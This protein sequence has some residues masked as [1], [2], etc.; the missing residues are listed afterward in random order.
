M[1]FVVCTRD[2]PLALYDQSTIAKL[3]GGGGGGGGGDRLHQQGCADHLKLMERTDALHFLSYVAPCLSRGDVMTTQQLDNLLIVSGLTRRDVG[4][5]DCTAA[6]GGGMHGALLVIQGRL[7]SKLYA[8][9]PVDITVET[10]ALQSDGS[11]NSTI[12]GLDEGVDNG[13]TAVHMKHKL[14]RLQ[15]LKFEITDAIG[16]I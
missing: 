16:S 4:T 9:M 14:L 3:G 10:V 13:S 8:D 5:D 6:G 7:P 12:D 15:S 11:R 2:A 1:K